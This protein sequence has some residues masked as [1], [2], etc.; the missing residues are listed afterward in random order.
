MM[1]PI[2]WSLPALV[3]IACSDT[4]P[5]VDEPRPA[6]SAS[7]PSALSTAPSYTLFESGQVRP[8]ALSPDRST[9]FAVNTPDNRLEVF[10]V[11]RGRLEHRGSVA[12]G[13]EPVAVAAR[14]DDEVWVVNHVSDSVSV[15]DVSNPKKPRV[16]R[17]LLV[18]DEPR[19]IVFAGPGKNRAFIT[20]AHRGQNSPVDPA[21]TTPGVGRADVW[22]FSATSQ[23]ASPLTIITLF[24]DTPRALAASPDGKRVYAAAFHSGNRTTV[25]ETNLVNPSLGLGLPP[26]TTNAIGETQ[27]SAPLIVKFNGQ[28]WVDELNRSWDDKVNFS[29]PD[30]DVFVLNAMANPPAPVAGPAGSFQGVGTILYN[31]AVNPVSG[32]VYVTNTEAFN[33]QRFEGPG[34]F[35]GHSVRG[36]F[37]H[38]RITV[39]DPATGGVAPRHLNK[40]INYSACCASIPNAENQKSLALP[41]GMAVSKN[42][43][44]LYVAALGS[45]KIGVFSTAALEADTFTPSLAHQIPLPGGGPTGVVLDEGRDQ[46]YA[47]TRFD[48]SIAVIDLDDRAEVARVP[49]HNPEPESVVRGRRFLYDASFSSSHGDSACASCHVFG[50]VDSLAWDLGDPDAVNTPMPGPFVVDPTLFGQPAEFA[51]LKGPMTTQPLRGLANHGPMHWRG[52]RTDTSGAP[53]A[54]PDSGIFDEDAAFKKFNVAF[55]GLLGRDAPIPAADMQAFTDFI[56]QVVYPPNPIRR[57]DNSL[58]PDQAAGKAFFLL[59]PSEGGPCASCHVLDP[60]ANAEHGVQFPGFFGT[61]GRYT[62]D[63]IFQSFKVAQLRGLYQKVG[64]FGMVENPRFNDRDH[65]FQGDQIRGFGFAHDGTVDTIFRFHDQLGFNEAPGVAGFPPGEEGDVLRRQVTDYL[66]VFESNLAPIVGQQVTLVGAGKPAILAR[67]A[68]LMARAEA[69]ECDLV[70]KGRIGGEEK[71]FLYQGDGTFRRNRAG[72][73]AIGAAALRLRAVAGHPL[74][75]TCA[76]PGAGVRM[77][78]DRDGDG[79]LD[80]DELDAGSDPAD[81]ASVPGS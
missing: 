74:T 33:E 16:V 25:V 21:L 50:D 57:L 69:G 22:V 26:P 41:Q 36:R 77:A 17:T 58:T 67:V 8:L 12:V 62:F 60:T 66:H 40:H 27:P 59:P 79:A 39:L 78:L 7:A 56:L 24:S 48:N 64:M 37:N 63:F 9:L 49:M 72:R 76:P 32:R 73:P 23:S 75:Y 28:H 20:T 70:V 14:N 42:G 4:G 31:M 81:P 45:D 52:D 80:G 61:D 53:S 44:K 5:R 18:G 35:A 68:L 46:L 51:A 3:I 54:Q 38:N 19:D 2:L 43:K 55:V 47:L 6:V 1:K 10:K 65:E 13:L 11:K 71:G 34:V 30:K 15:V 29:L